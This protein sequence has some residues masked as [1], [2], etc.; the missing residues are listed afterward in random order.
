[1]PSQGFTARKG[2]VPVAQCLEHEWRRNAVRH[3][4]VV[5]MKMTVMTHSVVRTIC[6]T[7]TFSNDYL[8]CLWDVQYFMLCIK[9]SRTWLQALDSKSTSTGLCFHLLHC[10][11]LSWAAYTHVSLVTKHL[12]WYLCWSKVN[13]HTMWCT[14]TAVKAVNCSEW[15]EFNAPP[16]T[17]SSQL[18]LLPS[19]RPRDRRSA[20][21]TTMIRWL[22]EALYPLF[23]RCIMFH[24]ELQYVVLGL[25]V[26]RS[27][28]LSIV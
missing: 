1:M 2:V 4:N 18:W 10:W 12:I 3:D 15:V 20:L 21:S 8:V 6:E 27:V 19:W 28:C 11:V 5:M 24:S 9:S 22:W 25:M 13:I 16:D 7:C 26:T 23:I 14:G 17:Y